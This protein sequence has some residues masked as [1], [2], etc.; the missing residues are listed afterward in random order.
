MHEETPLRSIT[1]KKDLSHNY[2]WYYPI[3][4]L[5]LEGKHTS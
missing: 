3:P 2:F 5:D 4:T 1:Q